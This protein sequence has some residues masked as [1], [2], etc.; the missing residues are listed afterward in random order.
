MENSTNRMSRLAKSDL[1]YKKIVT[2]EEVM[3]RVDQVTP[4]ELLRVARTLF[5]DNLLTLTAIGPFPPDYG[6][7]RW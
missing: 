6:L 7:E 5:Q 3:A 2:P 4:G 1:F